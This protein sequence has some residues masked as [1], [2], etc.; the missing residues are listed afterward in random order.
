MTRTAKIEIKQHIPEGKR[1]VGYRPAK[2]G[3]Q[4]MHL[5]GRDVRIADGDT[6]LEKVI[7]EDDV[8][9]WWLVMMG[10]SCLATCSSKDR[11]LTFCS[12]H[13][14]DLEIVKVKEVQQ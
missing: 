1:F 10:Q 7:V 4:Y 5:E 14:G 13:D 8:R 9:E 3:E 12:Q 6:L 11:A 2:K